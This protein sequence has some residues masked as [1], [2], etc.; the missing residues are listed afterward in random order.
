MKRMTGRGAAQEWQQH[1]EET[2]R[3]AGAL[4][5]ELPEGKPA[6]K[7][8]G[9]QRERNFLTQTRGLDRELERLARINEEFARGFRSF[10]KLGPAV[11]VFG[12]ARRNE[13]RPYHEV[14]G[15]AGRGLGARAD[16]RSGRT[17][18]CRTSRRRIRMWTRW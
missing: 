8:K 12:S 14:G 5:F 1:W 3:T 11:T 7:V 6:K 16:R 13:G 10:Y 17:S 9:L 18:F 2:W 15:G 4:G